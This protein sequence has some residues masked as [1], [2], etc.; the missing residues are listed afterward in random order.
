M[1]KITISGY[2][3]NDL[4][5]DINVRRSTSGMTFYVNGNLVTWSSQKQRCV[6]LSSCEPELMVSTSETCQGIWLR[7]LLTEIK[8]KKLEPTTF[9]VDNKSALDQMKNPVFHGRIKHI[10]IHYHFIRECVEN[11]EITVSHVCGKKQKADILTKAMA[12]VKHE[13]MRNLI[14]IKKV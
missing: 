6:T 9:F 12:K 5:V 4:G 8:G 3:H 2:S 1:G 13:E 7:R 11:G 10:D 14:G